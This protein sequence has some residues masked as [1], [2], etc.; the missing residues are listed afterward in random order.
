MKQNKGHSFVELIFVVVLISALAMIAVP[1]INFSIRSSI[2]GIQ[3]IPIEL[4]IFNCCFIGIRQQSDV[5]HHI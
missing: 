1:R 2:E 5:E 3:N 4:Q